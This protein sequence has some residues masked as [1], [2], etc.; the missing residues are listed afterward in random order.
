MRDIVYDFSLEDVALMLKNGLVLEAKNVP[1]TNA[2]LISK[3]FKQELELRTQKLSHLF[4]KDRFDD[5]ENGEQGEREAVTLPKA[6]T[7]IRNLT[8]EAV[9]DAC[10]TLE[11][12]DRWFG[13][14]TMQMDWLRSF[15]VKIIVPISKVSHDWDNDLWDDDM[16]DVL[17][18][19]RWQSWWK[20]REF[21]GLQV[22][23]AGCAEGEGLWWFLGGE[24]EATL[25]IE[26]KVV[27]GAKGQKRLQVWSRESDEQVVD[28]SEWDN[29]EEVWN[30]YVED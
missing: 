27:E 29:S 30:G 18:T 15:D 11:L 25:A 7:K 16:D 20:L 5:D 14:C 4:V 10:D 26:W 9:A 23:D 19:L 1:S 8:L 3:Q 28:F 24:H 12:P 21:K 2:L 22:F 6:A 17:R 13:I